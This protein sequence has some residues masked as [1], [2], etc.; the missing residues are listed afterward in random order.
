ML[1]LV[2]VIGTGL[3]LSSGGT[4][5]RTG[6]CG[7]FLSYLFVGVI[8]M[9]NQLAIAE[10]SCLMPV[11]ASTVRHSEHFLDE[12]VGFAYG[13]I[14][15]YSNILPT[16]LAA[17][18]V[19][20]T[21]WTDLNPAIFITVMAVV[22]VATNSYSVRFYGEV[23]FFFGILKLCLVVGLIICGFIIA[24]GGVKG[25]ERLGFHYWNDPG[26]FAEHL[27]SGSLGKFLGFWSAINSVVYAYGGLQ[28]IATLAAETENP[29]RS[30]WRAAKRVLIRVVT[31]YCLAVLILGMLVPFN[32]P[33]IATGTGTANS[34]PFVIAIKRAGIK[35]LDS[36]INGVVLT[37]AF[38]AGNLGL[39]HTSRTLFALAVKKQAPKIFLKTTKRGVP[40]V[41][42]YTTAAFL[43]LAYMSCSEAANNVFSWFQNIS[44]S[45]TL[46]FWILISANHIALT[47][48]MKVQGYSRDMLPYSTRFTPIFAWIS[49]FFS[50]LFLLTAGYPVF[51]HGMW[52]F[53]TFFTDY[54]I[55]PLFLVLA[56]G[57]KFIKKTR[58]IRSNEVDLATLFQDVEDH[59]EPPYEKITGWRWIQV[60]W[61]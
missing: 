52:S 44:S 22:E 43:P 7:M 10:T 17:A 25:Q 58:W 1:T 48:A 8:I 42:L 28:G 16:E 33:D 20:I 47:R 3:F 56:L 45:N 39:I 38:S 34:S 37:S 57:Y 55:I 46:L 21:Y 23:E 51:I 5:S 35:G 24:M 59:P 32:D 26:P 6:P 61:S 50:I 30:I 18:A 41:G 29:R 49:G 40:W 31:L 12:C 54:F 15:V 60:L 27:E 14:T 11:T 36:V 2:G 4:L 53:S 19:V 9:M 13:W